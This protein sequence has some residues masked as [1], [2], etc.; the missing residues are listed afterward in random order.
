MRRQET[1]ARARLAEMRKQM[2]DLDRQSAEREKLL[3]TRQAHRDKLEAERK[4]GQAALAAIE[5]RL[6][7]A[8]GESGFR[9]ERLRIIDPGIV[10]ER[11]SSPNLPLNVA[12]ALLAG[13][14]AADHS[15]SRSR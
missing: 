11:P 8:R 9:G 14:G 3:A 2:Q 12:A 13:P 5:T 4:A 1:N 10:P 7:D 6:R 15:T